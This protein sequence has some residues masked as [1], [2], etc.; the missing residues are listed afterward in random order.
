MP[1]KPVV[2]KV[3]PAVIAAKAGSQ[4]EGAEEH[5]LSIAGKRGLFGGQCSGCNWSMSSVPDV[6]T[7]EKAHKAHAGK[8]KE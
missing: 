4:N 7:I 2:V 3:E 8:F 6:E 5:G 1:K